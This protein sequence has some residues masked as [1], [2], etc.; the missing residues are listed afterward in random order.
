VAAR[1]LLTRAARSTWHFFMGVKNVFG[2]TDRFQASQQKFHNTFFFISDR[3]PGRCEEAGT[4]L[5]TSANSM[6][7]QA[8]TREAFS[9]LIDMTQPSI[10][11]ICCVVQCDGCPHCKFVCTF[12]VACTAHA[13]LWQHLWQHRAP[14]IRDPS[15]LHIVSGR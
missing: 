8:E 7:S 3:Y 15:I 14:Q 9:G 2:R 11:C 4:S 12:T 10:C 13:H 6:Q 1:L 5:G